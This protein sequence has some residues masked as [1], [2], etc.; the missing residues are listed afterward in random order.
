M[1]S[2]NNDSVF[3]LVNASDMFCSDYTEA[4]SFTLKYLYSS[5]TVCISI[6]GFFSVL[7]A[8]LVRTTK[9]AYYLSPYSKELVFLESFL[10]FF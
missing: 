9:K 5:L 3:S 1:V 10:P 4:T 2:S 7:Q 6:M 8:A